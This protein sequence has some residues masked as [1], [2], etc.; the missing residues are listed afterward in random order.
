MAKPVT[1]LH[2]SPSWSAC[3]QTDDL[4]GLANA[5]IA[6]ATRRPALSLIENG[7][8]A[9]L[10]DID[11]HRSR[12]RAHGMA[13][14]D[15]VWPDQPDLFVQAPDSWAATSSPCWSRNLEEAVQAAQRHGQVGGVFEAGSGPQIDLSLGCAAAPTHG[16]ELADLLEGDV[17][18]AWTPSAPAGRGR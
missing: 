14:G 17:I 2:A 16:N 8:G 15:L 12:Q 3:R 13:A 18:P 6:L 4:T 10:I 11:R 9:I 1:W 5:A 7:G